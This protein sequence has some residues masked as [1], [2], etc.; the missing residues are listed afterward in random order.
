MRPSGPDRPPPL[1][2]GAAYRAHHGALV[3]RAGGVLARAPFAEVCEPAVNRNLRLVAT[4]AAGAFERCAPRAPRVE[5][6]RAR[7]RILPI[8]LRI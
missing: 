6:L 3:A 5:R 4:P 8:I 7:P 1:K 2:V